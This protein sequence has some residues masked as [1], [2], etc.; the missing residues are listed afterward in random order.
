VKEH[1]H[2]LFV[3]LLTV[4][5]YLNSLNG[6]WAMDDAYIS[7]FASLKDYINLNLDFRKISYITFQLN[8][9]FTPNDVIYYRVVNVFLHCLNTVLLY[10]ISYITFKR[11]IEI[12]NPLLASLIVSLIFAVHPINNTSVAYIIQRMAL[13]S[14]FFVLLSLLCYIK[15]VLTENKIRSIAL[16]VLV[17]VF[18]FLGVFSKENALLAIPLIF[19]YDHIFLSKSRQGLPIYK[20]IYLSLGLSV[21][22]L[23][24]LYLLNADHTFRAIVKIAR[25]F[26]SPND[27]IRQEGWTCVDVY[28][29]PIE[30]L[31]TE[32][33]VIVRYLT[34][35]FIPIPTLFVFDWW[36]FPVSEGLFRPITTVFS[37]L[38]LILLTLASFIYRERYPLIAFAIL[39]YMVGLSMESFIA[40]GSDLYF[41]HRNYLPLT[42]LLVGI[43]G[44]IDRGVGL[45]DKGVITFISIFLLI[46]IF[47]TIKRNET[48]RDSITLWKDTIQKAPNNLRA[49]MSLGNAYL[50]AFMVKEAIDV[51]ND[52]LND[53]LIGR[54]PT[55]MLD[56]LFSKGMSS[57]YLGRLGEAKG[58][59][60]MMENSGYKSVK[61]VLLKSAIDI[62]DDRSEDAIKGLTQVIGD[63]KGLNLQV[64]TILLADAYRAQGDAERAVNTYRSVLKADPLNATSYYGIGKSYLIVGHREQA[65]FYLSR[66]ID[67]EPNNVFA[68]ADLSD[69]HLIN[70]E[71]D[72]AY[73]YA[74]RAIGLNTPFYKP[75]LAM[76]NVMLYKGA[77][78]EAERWYDQALSLHSPAYL[79]HYNKSR[80]YLLKNDREKAMLFLR[81]TLGQKDVPHLLKNKIEAYFKF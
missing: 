46:S 22:V 45:K 51:F 71:I 75:S 32:A 24:I 66:C 78:D 59:L 67:L 31:L 60:K 40:I 53:R 14:T 9:L 42:G 54:S 16:R 38:F 13:L 56:A 63:L 7:G 68:L 70:G 12:K 58:S 17:C 15:S 47:T 19:L 81:K 34:S 30:H 37:V 25:Y 21:F 79:I 52:V 69:L 73:H 29:T 72:K 4:L 44:Q 76:A 80:V 36:G 65:L 20:V 6:T 27:A 5:V 23:L 18:I 3:P 50:R 48:F 10:A 1:R 77:S 33:R 74:Q 41:E 62:S 39:W 35:I 26:L 8:H 28:W 11:F 49:K 61:T 55:F 43:V 2:I 57:V 64:A